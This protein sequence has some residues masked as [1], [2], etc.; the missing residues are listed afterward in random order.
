MVSN[1]SSQLF[2]QHVTMQ[3]R[4]KRKPDTDFLACFHIGLDLKRCMLGE[5]FHATGF[6]QVLQ[7]ILGVFDQLRFPLKKTDTHGEPAKER[8]VW[9]LKIVW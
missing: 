1:I 4:I 2:N 9:S 7:K 8:S 6:E 3:G 5:R